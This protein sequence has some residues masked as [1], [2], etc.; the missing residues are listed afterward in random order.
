MDM[1]HYDTLTEAVDAL[2]KQG[3]RTDLKLSEEG[4]CDYRKE[5]YLTKDDFQVDKHFRFEGM[6]NPSDQTIL[7][8]ITAPSKNVK[9]TLVQAYGLYGQDLPEG[10][11]EK[12]HH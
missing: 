2:K 3:Y 9:G 4:I 11:A 10:F 8:A 12:L 7:Y 1:E 6:T 5:V